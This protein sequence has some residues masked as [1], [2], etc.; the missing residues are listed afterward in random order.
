MCSK[1]KQKKQQVG[2]ELDVEL[3]QTFRE[4]FL[5][6]LYE[7]TGSCFCHH[8]GDL[9]IGVTLESFMRKFFMGWATHCQASSLVCRQILLN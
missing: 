8:D 2:L 1:E 6:C 4:G 3:R 5:A 9:D 7:S